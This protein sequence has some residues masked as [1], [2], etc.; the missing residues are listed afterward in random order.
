MSLSSDPVFSSALPTHGQLRG[1]LTQAGLRATRQRLVILESLLVLPGHP[2]AEQVHRRVAAQ[3]PTISLGT[4]YKALDSFVAAGLT[5]R[6]ASAE[7]SSRRYDADCSEHH[8]LFC[9]ATQEIIDYCDPQLDQLIRE[10][11]AERG[12][13]NFQPHSFS[14]HITGVKNQG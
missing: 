2:T 8:H 1:R 3:S 7:G 11:F 10:F 12:L 14:L 6:V 5:R 4:V 13:Q 9:T